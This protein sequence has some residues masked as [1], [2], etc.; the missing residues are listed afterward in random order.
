MKIRNNKYIIIFCSI[1]FFLTACN[2][3]FDELA[4][5]PN[6]LS[7]N[8]FFD[9]PEGVDQA[10]KGIYGYL[11]TPRNLGSLG[12]GMYMHH[13]SDE[14]SSGTNQAVSGQHNSKLGPNL[15]SIQQP[16]A[17]MYTAAFQATGVIENADDADYEG[18]T[19]LRDA[20]V[21]EAHCLRAF[22]HYFLL[23]NFRNIVVIDKV[24]SDD[25]ELI[26]GQVSPDEAWDFIISDLI[27][28]KELLPNKDFWDSSNT[29]RMTAG[30][31]AGLLG[32]VYLTRSGIE[33]I[34]RYN[35]AASEFADIINGVYG[36]YGLTPNYNDNFGV[37]N[38]N[39]EESVLEFQFVGDG[40]Q[41]R[42]FDPGLVISGLFSDPVGF[43]PP[44]LRGFDAVVHDW[45]YD[46]YAAS[47]DND[48]RTDRR[49]F[50]TLVFDDRLLPNGIP[51]LN[52]DN[53]FTNDRLALNA[54]HTFEEVYF[55]DGTFGG[56]WPQAAAYK[57]ANRKWLDW[58][59]NIE[60]EYSGRNDRFRETRAHG[61]N[62]RFIRYADILLMYA[63]CVLN[64]ANASAGSA[65]E[66]VNV[67]RARADVPVLGALDMDA[68]RTERI[69]ELSL[70]GHR[71]V[72]LLRWGTIQA[73][74]SFLENS[75]PNFKQFDDGTYFPFESPKNL[76]LPIP[77]DEIQSN[78]NIIQ[79]DGW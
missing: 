37:E 47:I 79:N 36:P 74:M 65:L 9:T 18:N 33:G 55:E 57:A 48:G 45:L 10:V 78:P 1:C 40:D 4:V 2:D 20:Y 73:R 70:E 39:N 64:G 23:T 44:G 67:V 5:N 31:A 21:G 53:D 56:K 27:K 7:L 60:G 8:G 24:P 14:M 75:D 32:K 76:Y 68:L 11:A 22:V 43:S 63:E 28:A 17:L 50:G 34:D 6:E 49:M 72:D 25:S 12:K 77:I 69:L 29:G 26:K 71:G 52:N 13:R 61:A 19:E 58:N 66:A 42:E 41:N 46:F 15:F 16:W 62:W 30:A 59:L 54:G 38:E 35:E 51:D 3:D